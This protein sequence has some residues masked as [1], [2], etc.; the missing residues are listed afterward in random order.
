MALALFDLDHTLLNGDSDYL[1]GQ[2]LAARGDVDTAHH[3][4]E[5]HRFFEQYRAGTLDIHAYFHFTLGPIAAADPAQL[6][7]W[8]ADFLESVIKPIIPQR[9]RERLA[10]HRRNG[11][12]LVII[13]A[14]NSVITRPIATELG[15]AN[16]LATEPRIDGGRY[17]RDIEGPPCFREGK[18]DKLAQWL[19]RRNQTPDWA[20][21]YFYSDSHNDIPLLSKEGNPVAVNPDPK[22]RTHAETQGW[23][24]I[25]LRDSTH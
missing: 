13:T 2:Y 9:S 14:T 18:I 11:D 3:A 1:W 8:L 16:L 21:S 20:S 12:E 4:R 10:Q 6:K 24:I 19:S 23:P 5:N 15:V 22:L 25:S 17:G 7:Q